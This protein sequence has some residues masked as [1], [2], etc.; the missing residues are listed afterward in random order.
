[1]SKIGTLN[2]KTKTVSARINITEE[3]LLESK[4]QQ[5]GIPKSKYV[6]ALIRADLESTM[7]TFEFY[8]A[9]NK[10]KSYEARIDKE[11]IE[12]IRNELRKENQKILTEVE[13]ISE[14]NIN[15]MLKLKDELEYAKSAIDKEA[16]IVMTMLM[17]A[18]KLVNHINR[19]DE[20]ED[21]IFERLNN[22]V[23][24]NISYVQY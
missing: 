23:D 15:L 6:E 13:A 1:M 12:E 24:Q 16:S 7:P 20:S 18:Y 10:E 17:V 9:D 3:T 22:D 14:R 11:N 19:I 2:S 21:E 4:A 5:L 8:N